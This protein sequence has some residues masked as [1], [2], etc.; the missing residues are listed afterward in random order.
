V[1]RY[2]ARHLFNPPS[3][4]SWTRVALA[5][6][7]VQVAGSVALTLVVL[8][9]AAV[10]DIADGFV[11]RRFGLATPTGA[12]LDAV[13]DKV[14]AAT[15]LT[16]LVLAGRLTLIN[17]ALLGAREIV[18]APLVFLLAVRPA[19]R[20]RRVDERANVFGKAATTLQ[21][22]TVVAVLAGSPL[23]SVGVWLTAAVGVAAGLTYWRRLAGARTPLRTSR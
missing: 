2:E 19:V 1:S 21:F 5:F 3:L 14:F 11:A 18:E 12:V 7:F 9:L 17:V 4:I 20:L 16:T 22:A 10:S 23:V 6:A 15:V 13:T 8:A